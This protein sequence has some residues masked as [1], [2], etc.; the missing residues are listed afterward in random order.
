MSEDTHPVDVPGPADEELIPTSD[1]YPRMILVCMGIS[2][3]LVVIIFG[4][5]FLDFMQRTDQDVRPYARPSAA[6]VETPGAE[7]PSQVPSAS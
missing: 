2:L 6:P 1:P 7:S 5:I 4:C 3:V